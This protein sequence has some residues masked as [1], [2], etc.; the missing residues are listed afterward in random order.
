MSKNLIYIIVFIILLIIFITAFSSSYTSRKLDNLAYVLALGIDV[1]ENASLKLSAQFTK[2]ASFSPSE[3]SSSEDSD[4]IVLVSVEADSLFSAINL[5]N[6]YIGKEINLSHCSF[7]VFSEEFAKNGISTEIYSL[8]NNEEIRPTS[9]LLISTC[10]A[11]DYLNNSYPNLE[12]LSTQYYKTFTI[13][14]RFTGYF[15]SITIGDFFNSL[16]ADYY[17]CTA[18]LGGLNATARKST[19]KDSSSNNEVAQTQN[20]ITNPENLTAGTSSIIGNRGTENLGIAV[21]K[22]DKLCGK[23]SV[24]ESICHS[25]INNTVDSCIISI[26]NPLIKLEEPEKM[27]IQL[28]PSK[29]TKIEV[30]IKNNKPY[31]SIKVS[32]EAD[33]MTLAPNIN[34]D[35]NEALSIVSE[36]SKQFLE[37]QFY[38]YLN[39]V[40]TEYN[41]DID[42]FSTKIAAHFATIS[43]FKNF[44]WIEKYKDSEFDV[45]VD[46][47][48]ISSLLLNKT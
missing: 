22:D 9:N 37:E 25:L 46:I 43:D 24:I 6:S 5:L 17:D 20:I 29:D 10:S 48:V 27:E 32:L 36:A 44:N 42:Q 35:T 47:N 1:G 21:F 18:I 28:F 31:I 19:E 26:D 14:D 33:I 11:Y 23:L 45:N 12:K 13:T 39:K 16:S 34:Y 38:K 3:G 4:N 7:I 2:S 15:S 30:L 41:T 8:I 40:C